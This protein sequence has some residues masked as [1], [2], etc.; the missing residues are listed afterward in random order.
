MPYLN[1]LDL[2]LNI[3]K[4]KFFTFL[5]YMVSLTLL[6]W[7]SAMLGIL[8]FDLKICR[9]ISGLFLIESFHFINMS[10]SIPTKHYYLSSDT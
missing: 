3:G 2:S 1:S 8:S 7:I 4:L 10:N 6:L 9:D 5:D